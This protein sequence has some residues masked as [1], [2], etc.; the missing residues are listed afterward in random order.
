MVVLAYRH[1][2]HQL[3]HRGIDRTRCNAVGADTDG[4]ELRRQLPRELD[5]PRLA[6]AV[7]DAQ[8][9]RAQSRNRRDVHDTAAAGLQHDGRARFG[10]DEGAGEVDRKDVIPVRERRFQDRLEHRDAGIVHERI[11]PAELLRDAPYGRLYLLGIGHVAGNRQY[12][13]RMVQ[14]ASSAR[15]LPAVDVQQGN[16]VP[17][18]K[19]PLGDREA[20]PA[21]ASRDD[22]NQRIRS[23]FP[24]HVPLRLA[25]ILRRIN[26]KRAGVITSGRRSPERMPRSSASS[27]AEAGCREAGADYCLRRRDAANPANPKPRSARVPGSGT[28]AGVSRSGAANSTT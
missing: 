21:R 18:R 2:M 9:A 16:A 19:K 23:C 25:Q 7:G 28:A 5:Q 13:K 12:P 6:G 27:N 4:A 17:I 26:V 11:D 14:A 20:D 3:R 24:W 22:G 15:Q 10:A 8:G 1:R